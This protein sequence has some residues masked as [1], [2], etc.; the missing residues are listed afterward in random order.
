[1]SGEFDLAAMLRRQLQRDEMDA[2]DTAVPA[3]HDLV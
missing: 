1:M 3:E 2:K